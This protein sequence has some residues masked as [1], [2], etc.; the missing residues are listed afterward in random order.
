MT[1][2]ISVRLDEQDLAAIDAACGDVPR[3]RWIRSVLADAVRQTLEAKPSDTEGARPSDQAGPAPVLSGS[4]I[5]PES[6]RPAA[7]PRTPDPIALA[8]QEKINKAA[9]RARKKQKP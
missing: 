8:R 9:E 3:E 1:K 4:P 5:S 6:V 2:Q 7:S